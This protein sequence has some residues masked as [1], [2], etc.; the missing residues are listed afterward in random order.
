M[1]P[2]L[3]RNLIAENESFHIQEDIL[4]HFYDF[5]HYHPEI[6]LTLIVKSKGTV[7]IGDKICPFEAGDLFLL[8]PGLPH[9]FLDKVD[10]QKGDADPEGVHA[11][12]IYFKLNSFG[13]DFFNLPENHLIKEL[14]QKSSRGLKFAGE[15]KQQI[16]AKIEKLKIKKGTELLL[17]FFEI[18][19]ILSKGEEFESVSSVS[20][21]K[22]KDE[23]ES[24]RI[25]SIFRYVMDNFSREI[26]LEEISAI[27]AMNVTSFCRFF[28]QRTRKTFTMFVNEVRIGHACKE[29]LYNNYN[30][31]EVAYRCG[32]NNIS[33]FNRQFKGITG[34]TP[35]EYAKKI[36]RTN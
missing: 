24:K 26:T 25:E 30:I 23:S 22:T 8:G 20:F 18:L 12:S 11:I 7:I 32:F 15:S 10:A 5:L 34:L 4:A 16:P 29:L 28:K 9:V 17:E 14:L 19:N 3:F 27:S 1:K 13:D 31:N 6:Q 21:M 35:S 36:V 33:N 2:I